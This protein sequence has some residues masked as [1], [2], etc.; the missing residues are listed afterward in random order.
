M[1]DL[2]HNETVTL[3]Q[4][5]Q[6]AI[7]QRLFELFTAMP[8]KVVSYESST[9]LATIEPQIKRKYIDGDSFTLP[10]ITHVPVMHPR[11]SKAHMR[12]PV[13]VGDTGLIIWSQRSIDIWLEQGR[14]VDPEDS[15]KFNISDAAFYPGLFAK[16]SLMAIS[17]SVTSMELKNDKAFIDIESNGTIKIKNP[18]TTVTIKQSGEITTTNGVYT[19]TITNDGN[20]TVENGENTFKINKDGTYRVA[21]SSEELL[22]L[23]SRLIDTIINA[24]TN[25][26]FGP[27]PLIPDGADLFTTLKT[28]LDTLKE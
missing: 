15:R 28:K 11:T 2:R 1:A 23:L 4:F 20:V 3:Y 21:N 5:V 17:G 27:Q 6:N 24:R 26:I 22:D 10:L 13:A 7:E 9:A 18:R 16:N 8:G 12:L 19:E 14:A 25:T